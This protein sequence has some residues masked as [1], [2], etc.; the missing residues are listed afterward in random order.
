MS[1]RLL[2]KTNLK[3]SEIRDALAA[4]G[5]VV[6]NNT[7]TFFKRDANV[8]F[9]SKYKPVTVINGPEFVQDF[10]PN[11]EYYE[12]NWWK[13]KDGNCGVNVQATNGITMFIANMRDGNYGWEY[14]LPENP[15]R[16]GDFRN[17]DIDA[18]C[19]ISGEFQDDYWVELDRLTF[20]L[21]VEMDLP[22]T[23]L[24]L[25][26]ILVN[27]PDNGGLTKLSDYY[28]GVLLWKEV[29]GTVTDY[30]YPTSTNKAGTETITLTLDGFDGN[31]QWGEWYA[32]P[33]LS[34]VPQSLRGD[35]QVAANVSLNVAP[36]KIYVHAPGTLVYTIALAGYVTDGLGNA[37]V[38]YSIEIE[39]NDSSTKKAL[40]IELWIM[41]TSN[42]KPAEGNNVGTPAKVSF[43]S[44]QI[45][46][47]SSL[48]YF[49]DNYEGADNDLKRAE[50]FTIRSEVFDPNSYTYWIGS[51]AEGF[52]TTYVQIE[53]IQPEE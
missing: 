35:E 46:A 25:D 4:G 24:T 48:I 26:D 7:L 53:M 30:I 43:E 10:N 8:N 20:T 15:Y 34:S 51:R 52:A 50:G 17:Y 27:V 49:S 32:M 13:S 44:D 31:A 9:W 23:N 12:P 33:Y 22:D 11:E 40:T 47:N 3:A 1:H 42:G 14:V 16:L 39:N 37:Q 29:N 2:N 36:K 41:Q 6:S 38:S 18:H 5:G 21:D 45:E 19:P 28:P